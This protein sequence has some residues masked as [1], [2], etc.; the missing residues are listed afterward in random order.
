MG[1]L[2]PM[3]EEFVSVN[4]TSHRVCP[5]DRFPLSDIPGHRE[6]SLEMTG[7]GNY[8]VTRAAKY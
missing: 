3:Q 8:I 5:C 6:I 7:I 4:S 1:S 2:I